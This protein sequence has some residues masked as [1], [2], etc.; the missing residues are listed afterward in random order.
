V[1]IIRSVKIFRTPRL[2][3]TVAGASV[4]LAILAILVCTRSTAAEAPSAGGS[5]HSNLTSPLAVNSTQRFEQSV[6]RLSQLI[7]FTLLVLRRAAS[8][9]FVATSNRTVSGIGGTT[10]SPFSSPFGSGILALPTSL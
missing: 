4:L 9:E 7:I 1:L 5:K 6:I 2:D 10:A 3:A 8:P